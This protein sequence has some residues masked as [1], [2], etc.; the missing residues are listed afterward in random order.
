MTRHGETLW[1]E[2]RR[3]QGG[4]NDIALS[5]AG[6]TQVQKLGLALKDTGI[7]AIYSSP[8]SRALETA[9]AIAY[10]HS[11]DVIIKREL[12]EIDVGEFEG[13]TLESL[14]NDFSTFLP[15]S[16]TFYY[17]MLVK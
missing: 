1:N 7:D 9:Q 10:Y 12:R 17:S 13:R 6:R 8:L 11:I 2:Q 4:Q 3:I 16:C 15:S 5:D 14:K